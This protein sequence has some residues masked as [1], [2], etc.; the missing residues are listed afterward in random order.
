M[1]KIPTT[2]KVE[3]GLLPAS[4]LRKLG[5]GDDAGITGL[6]PAAYHLDGTRLHDAI[7]ASWNALRSRWASF[8]AAFEKLPE[9]DWATSLTRD[10]F[11]LPLFA[12]LQYGRLLPEKSREIDGTE[13]PISHYWRNS[14]I[15]LL[16]YR[17][18]LDKRTH[19]IQGAAR[20]SLIAW[21]RII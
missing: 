20:N 10:R 15:H 11:L 14:P 1:D 5:A 12:D 2:I 9:S 8:Q 19:G 3:G 7:S 21:F 13:Y 18:P 6:D 16:G 17:V 4:F